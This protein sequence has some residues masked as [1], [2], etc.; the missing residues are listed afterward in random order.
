M[1]LIRFVDECDKICYLNPDHII[2]IDENEVID[3]QDSSPCGYKFMGVTRIILR[4]QHEIYTKESLD[5][6]YKR[7]VLGW[8]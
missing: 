3:V 7:L 4:D 1:K 5:D 6:V 2:G 8:K